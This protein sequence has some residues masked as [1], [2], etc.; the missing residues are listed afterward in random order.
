MKPEKV[1]P[2]PH[3]VNEIE[4]PKN[5]YIINT[6]VFCERTFNHKCVDHY[7]TLLLGEKAKCC[8]YGFGSDILKV[9]K[10]K[11]VITGLNVIGISD[12]KI[13]RR[14]LHEK[15]VSVQ[16]AKAKYERVKERTVDLLGPL[17]QLQEKSEEIN[18]N[19]VFINE[20][21]DLLDTTFHELRKLNAQLKR[22]S[23]LLNQEVEGYELD[24]ER[25]KY[26][27]LNVFNTSRL[28]SIRL[29][30]YDFL[31]NP[32]LNALA[33]KKPIRVFKK[34]EKTIHCLKVASDQK[35]VRIGIRGT[36]HKRVNANDLFELLPF[37]LLENAMKYSP[38]GNEVEVKIVETY[39]DQ[40]HVRISNLGPRP[41][42]DEIDKLV[43]KGFRSSKVNGIE[44]GSGLGLFL[45][46]AICDLHSISMEIKIG[47]Q[48]TFVNQLAYSDFAVTLR[49][50]ALD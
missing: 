11:I 36:S 32:E 49:M 2:F 45:A 19:E 37:L 15:D 8:P 13:I 7:K 38:K 12:K 29:N 9:G 30:T 33:I 27:A 31:L 40:I 20:N 16:F 34:I 1:I 23:E 25:I 48:R 5:G 35:S 14:N 28:I 50:N 18:K 43:E 6:P 46:Q 22:Q 42:D 24:K 41:E 4:I 39:D 3:L 26:L 44:S 21:K 47:E 17:Y 10:K